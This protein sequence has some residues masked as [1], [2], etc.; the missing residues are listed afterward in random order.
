MSSAQFVGAGEAVPILTYHSLDD[1]GAVTSVA[2][3]D[4]QKHM[5]SLAHRRFTGINLRELLD[6]WDGAGTL[7]ARPV[8]LT[9]DDGFTSVLEHA[10]PVLSELGFRATVFA[11]SGRC[12]QTN[13]WPHQAPDIPR[14]PLLSWSELAQMAPVGFEIGAHTVTHRRLPDLPTE[15]ARQ[16]ILDSKK[17]IEER[18]GCEV[19]T[20]AFPFGRFTR[21]TYETVRENFCAACGVNLAKARPTDDRH[22]LSRLDIY[23]LRSP[24]MFKLFETAPGRVYLQL[25][26]IGRS[27]VRV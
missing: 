21:T 5:R 1:S 13:D 11:V 18:L 27:L 12:G 17:M 3:G 25:R 2:P 9:F 6:G 20:F 24:W 19:S 4:F 16:E 26:A 22:Q 7:P 23:Y 15:E 14:L 10:A 8:V